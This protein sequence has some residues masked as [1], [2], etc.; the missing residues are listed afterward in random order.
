MA[1]ST[2]VDSEPSDPKPALKLIATAVADLPH[3]L[4][5]MPNSQI[6]PDDLPNTT[7]LGC[8]PAALWQFAE[9]DANGMQFSPRRLGVSRAGLLLPGLVIVDFRRRLLKQGNTNSARK[10]HAPHDRRD[11]PVDL[12]HCQLRIFPPGGP[13]GPLPKTNDSR[14]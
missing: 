14:R 11:R 10:P 6:A 7:A 2:P 4:A 9:S 3:V 1:D 12:A 5:D 8:S 13:D